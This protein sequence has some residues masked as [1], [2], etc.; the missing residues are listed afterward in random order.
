MNKQNQ[1][2]LTIIASIVVVAIVAVGIFIFVS[3]DSASSGSDIDYTNV[4]MER[5]DDGGFI[6]GD[7][8]AP[9]T[10]VEF[11]DFLCPHCQ[12]YKSTVD[13]VINDFVL[14][15]QARFEY[16]MLPT[17]NLSPFVGQVAECAAVEY[18]GG[19][20]PI[21]DELFRIAN[22][23]RISDDIGR[24]IAEEF[25]LDYSTILTCTR[26]AEQVSIDQRL[27]TQ[28]GVSGTPAIRVRYGDSGLQ[29]ISAS[30]ERGSVPFEIIQAAVAN[31]Q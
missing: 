15:G 28:A 22:S 6:L 26:D 4:V 27:A 23:S 9:I 2:Q 16:R 3:R 5:T 13:R 18:E 19:F 20:W 7:P 1:Q 8:D 10:I 24:R 21:H 31:A 12:A 25:N 29:P 14:T 30:Y 17:Q 11:A